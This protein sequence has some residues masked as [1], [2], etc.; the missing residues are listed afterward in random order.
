MRFMHSKFIVNAILNLDCTF[1]DG[2]SRFNY[3]IIS[4]NSISLI[5]SPGIKVADAILKF[6]I[7]ISRIETEWLCIY[8]IDKYSN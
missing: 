4:I 1:S 2:L 7:E 3:N 6:F 8:L 5:T